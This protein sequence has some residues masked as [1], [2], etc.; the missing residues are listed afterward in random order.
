[1]ELFGAVQDNSPNLVDANPPPGTDYSNFYG[2]NVSVQ[3]PQTMGA[4]A[5]SPLA[6]PGVNGY[7]SGG[8]WVPGAR[9]QTQVQVPQAAPAPSVAPSVAAPSQIPFPQAP[10]QTPVAPTPPHAAPAPTPLS[11]LTVPSGPSFNGGISGGS[12]APSNPYSAP[13]YTPPA[14]PLAYAQLGAQMQGAPGANP[15]GASPTVSSGEGA[16]LTLRGG[17]SQNVG[18]MPGASGM[19]GMPGNIPPTQASAPVGFGSPVALAGG[20]AT[21]SNLPA[22]AA[23]TTPNVAGPADRG[24]A[25]TNGVPAPKPAP[26]IQGPGAPIPTPIGQPP[27]GAAIAAQAGKPANKQ[28]AAQK[29]AQTAAAA[30]P[31][32]VG[33]KM[34]ASFATDLFGRTQALDDE[35]NASRRL[36]EDQIDRAQRPAKRALAAKSYPYTKKGG[37][38]EQGNAAFNEAMQALKKAND[39]AEG[40]LTPDE[41]HSMEH[42]VQRNMDQA[43]AYEKL[44]AG[45]QRRAGINPNDVKDAYEVPAEKTAAAETLAAIKRREDHQIGIFER[46]MAHYG[47]IQKGYNE[48]LDNNIKEMGSLRAE[49]AAAM[50]IFENTAKAQYEALHQLGGTLA[51]ALYHGET[52][53]VANANLAVQ[54]AKLTMEQQQNDAKRAD[55]RRKEMHDDTAQLLTRLNHNDGLKMQALRDAKMDDDAKAKA[56]AEIDADS[57]RYNKAFQ[58][59]WEPKQ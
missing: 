16:P 14:N 1:M 25:M 32:L 58:E 44:I 4:S 54:Q 23:G 2:G 20:Q 41:E 24:E 28:E 51:N 8:F 47:A 7:W 17:V 46:E 40:V 42:I 10:A 48:M 53:M 52:S 9:P 31:N 55:A 37:L 26:N 33:L 50:A 30:N 12:A 19:S 13:S 15:G 27:N 5:G 3:A 39:Y 38:L 11:P 49:K 36:Q 45:Q 57:A 59:K 22:P 35:V 34:M 29:V 21:A 6:V 43:H 56:I 18:S